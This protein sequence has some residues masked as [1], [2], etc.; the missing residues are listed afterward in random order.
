M[1]ADIWLVIDTG[2]SEKARLTDPSI[3]VTYNLSKMLKEAGYPGHN[4]IM[5]APAG[6]AGGVLQ[7]VLDR[8]EA[9]PEHFR[10]FNPP[11]GWGTYDGAVSF[12]RRFRDECARHP[13][14]F[15]DGW[16]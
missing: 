3:H 5:G 4:E 2:G 15:V 14:A 11:N 9:N 12:I 7:G 1:S 13:Q 16:L 6:E 8:L 10:Q